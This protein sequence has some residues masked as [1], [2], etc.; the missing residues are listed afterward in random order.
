MS[1]YKGFSHRLP[2]SLTKSAS[3]AAAVWHFVL[4]ADVPDSPAGPGT[5]GGIMSDLFWDTIDIQGR[6]CVVTTCDGI[7]KMGAWNW[8]GFDKDDREGTLTASYVGPEAYSAGDV[9]LCWLYF[10]GPTTAGGIPNTTNYTL[11]PQVDMIMPTE[12]IVP[13]RPEQSG[14]TAPAAN[15]PVLAGTATFDQVLSIFWDVTEILGG[16]VA[17]YNRAMGFREIVIFQCEAFDET[18]AG[19]SILDN[20]E[21]SVVVYNGRTYCKTWIDGLQDGTNYTICLTVMTRIYVSNPQTKIHQFRCS[22][23]TINPV[24][25]T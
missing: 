13:C 21:N 7:T 22:I 3:E 14:A 8:A 6:Q 4:E 24:T 15:F 1:W 19:A 16:R 25:P 10:G 11:S 2:I 17:P 9:K 12:M 23:E 20:E 18:G 5:H